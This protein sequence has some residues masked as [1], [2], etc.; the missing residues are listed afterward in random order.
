MSK[1]IKGSTKKG[2]NLIARGS[3]Y[4]GTYLS[5]VYDNWSSAKERAWNDCYEKYMNTEDATAFSICSFNTF[6]FSVSWLG[7]YEGENAMFIE[8]S[9]NSYII[10]LDK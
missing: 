7:L 5:Q 6:Q 10:L 2:E 9:S 8:T 1:I 3:R 4:E